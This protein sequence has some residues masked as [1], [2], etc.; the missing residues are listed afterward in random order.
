MSRRATP[1]TP[2]G[3]AP[4]RPLRADA[5]R[6]R[7]RIIAAARE[8]FAERGVDVTLDDIARHAGVGVGTVYRRFA[9]REELIEAVFEDQVERLAVVAEEAARCEDPWT[10]LEQLLLVTGQ[11]FA[12][13][14]GLRDV[15]LDSAPDR[16]RAVSMRE[17]LTPAV[18]AVLTRAQQAG[19][20]RDDIE[21]TDVPLIHVMLMAAAEQG[22]AVT[23]DLWKR[24]LTLILDGLRHDRERPTPLPQRALDQGEF[25]RA[26]R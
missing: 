9:D 10:G 6:N 15:L 24:Y 4:A 22:R 5:E 2:S 23:P 25:D 18:A 3:S 12:D 19:L 17:R 8:V 21:P 26:M 16:R 1:A 11:Y 13:N 14:R 20:L 7:Q